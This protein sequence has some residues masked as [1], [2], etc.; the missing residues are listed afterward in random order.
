MKKMNNSNLNHPFFI[1][2]RGFMSEYNNYKLYRREVVKLNEFMN[3]L[4]V[5][6]IEKHSDKDVLVPLIIGSVME[7]FI[8]KSNTSSDN[9]FQYRQLFPNYINNFIKSNP[10]NKF[11][12]IIIVSPDNIFESESYVPIFTLYE[13]F[14]FVLTNPNEYLYYDESITIKV[15]I[16]NCPFPCID[17]RNS[18]IS[19]YETIIKTL[20]VNPYNILSYAQTPNDLEFIDIF[21][22]RIDR[23]FSLT[24]NSQIKIII[25][26]WVSFKNLDGISENYNMFP[27]L[28][29]LANKYNIIATEWDF[30]DELFYTRII[31]KYRFENVELYGIKINYVFNEFLSD[32]PDNVLKMNFDLKKMFIIDFNSKYFIKK[33]D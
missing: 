24:S 23:L 32:L 4:F 20:E 16:F 2:P 21:Y 27:K 14:D 5:D 18:L 12:Q 15:N 31:S 11:I 28:L 29:S 17:S 25:N 6:I 26:S 9:Y 13:S 1:Y 30:I 7:D 19:R 10:N 8:I 33:I 22:S 3:E